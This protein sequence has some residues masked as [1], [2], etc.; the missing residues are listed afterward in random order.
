MQV[1]VFLICGTAIWAVREKMLAEV[2]R[3]LPD[4]EQIFILLW[5]LFGLSL[6]HLT[7]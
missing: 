4:G 5:M 3:K 6:L 7:W 2:N 1:A